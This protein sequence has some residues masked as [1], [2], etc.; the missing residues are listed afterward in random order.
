MKYLTRKPLYGFLPDTTR[1]IGYATKE[2]SFPPAIMIV[3]CIM[4]TTVTIVGKS[5]QSYH[6]PSFF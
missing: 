3:R 1:I 2:A 4:H 5:L 6:E